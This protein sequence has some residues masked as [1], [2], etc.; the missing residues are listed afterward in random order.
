MVATI[1]THLYNQVG[2]I[3][4]KETFCDLSGWAGDLQQLM[5]QELFKDKKQYRHD[6]SLGYYYDI[7]INSPVED[8]YNCT[9]DF[10][11]NS[12]TFGIEDVYADMDAVN[13]YN[14]L[15][16]DKNIADVLDDYYSNFSMNRQEMFIHNVLGHETVDS[17]ITYEDKIFFN[18]RVLK[19]TRLKADS[20]FCFNWPLLSNIQNIAGDAS[21][22]ISNAFTNYVFEGIEIENS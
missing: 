17:V 5:N 20:I 18:S 19:Y 21:V 4:S 15:S 11:G 22:N 12:S 13:I 10:L 9:Y 8:T 7:P 2:L 6:T 16:D 3:F 14:M 1:N